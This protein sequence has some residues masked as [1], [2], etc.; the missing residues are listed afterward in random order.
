MFAS[1][2]DDLFLICNFT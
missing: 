1:I 2:F